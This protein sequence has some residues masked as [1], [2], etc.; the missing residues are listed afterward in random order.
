MS[1]PDDPAAWVV[2]ADNDLLN[3]ANNL[4]DAHIPWDTVC[5]HAQQAAEK[6]LKAFLVSHGLMPPRTH[7]LIA[8]LNQCF[9]RHTAFATMESDCRLLLQYAVESRYPQA[10]FEPT[11]VEG[12][13]AVAAAR[14]V[15]EFVRIAMR[16]K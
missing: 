13:E 1:D 9:A 12:T 16:S 3:I 8:L 2:K 11:E 4:N 7:D 15:C 6:M 5:F 14:R 10:M